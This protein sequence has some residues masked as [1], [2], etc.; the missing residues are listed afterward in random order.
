MGVERGEVERYIGGWEGMK[1][2]GMD[3]WREKD[4]GGCFE[5]VI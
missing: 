3:R 5:T 2:Q 4:K 1:A